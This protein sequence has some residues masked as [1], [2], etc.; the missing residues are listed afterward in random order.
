V[1]GVTGTPFFISAVLAK[2]KTAPVFDPV[3]GQT[4]KGQFWTFAR[5]ERLW[6][7]QASTRRI[8][9]IS[10]KRS[11]VVEV[12]IAD[13]YHFT[14]QIVGRRL[15]ATIIRFPALVAPRFVH[16]FGQLDPAPPGTFS[17]AHASQTSH[18]REDAG[19]D[20]T[21]GYKEHVPTPKVFSVRL[22]RPWPNS[23]PA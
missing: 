12:V 6:R 21:I 18:D 8:A 7:R 9:S 17:P 20:P 15:A 19:D 3:S 5:D 11:W 13:N 2:L 22:G 16:Q 10:K 1:H 23:Y 14:S 4:K